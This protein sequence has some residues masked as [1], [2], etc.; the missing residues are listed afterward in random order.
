MET[1]MYDAPSHGSFVNLKSINRY[2]DGDTV[3]MDFAPHWDKQG[4]EWLR[5][6]LGEII[7]DMDKP[8]T[9]THA[10]FNSDNPPI[11]L[12]SGRLYPVSDFNGVSFR[13]TKPDGTVNLCLVNGCSHVDPAQWTLV[14]PD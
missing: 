14:Y 5:D 8:K 6:K 3:T 2:P 1:E 11:Y 4:L 13:I 9:P 12:E 10:V 7:S